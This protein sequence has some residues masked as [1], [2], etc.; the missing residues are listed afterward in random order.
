MHW[1]C[2]C[3][4]SIGVTTNLDKKNKCFRP[5]PNISTSS[6]RARSQ[7]KTREEGK[8]R[9]SF[10]VVLS[11]LGVHHPFCSRPSAATERATDCLPL[12]CVNRF[13]PLISL[14]PSLSAATAFRFVIRAHTYGKWAVYICTYMLICGPPTPTSETKL[15]NDVR[16][17][18][19]A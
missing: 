1:C 17:P 4:H 9:I 7:K 12:P 5:P 18:I 19:R 3:V 6:P 13:M 16:F 11:V 14:S 15:R 10:V 8:D 2:E